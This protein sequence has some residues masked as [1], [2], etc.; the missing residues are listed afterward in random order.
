MLLRILI[1]IIIFLAVSICAVAQKTT[2]YL[3]PVNEY[4]QAMELYEH[5]KYGAAQKQFRKAIRK[6]SDKNSET[7]IN[8]EYYA[9]LC[10]AELFHKDAEFLFRQFIQAHPES[11]K[12]RLAHFQLGRYNFRKKSWERTVEWLAK[13]DIYDLS[14]EELPEYYFKLGYSYFMID[15][16]ES[17]SKA[18]FEIKDVDTKYTAPANYYY[19]HIAYFKGNYET[20]LGGFKRL[21]NHEKFK[22]VIPYYITQIYYKQEKYDDVISYAPP[23]LDS[24]STRRAPEI[25]RL[26]G[27]SYYRTNR[28]KESV[29]YLEKYKQGVGAGALKK[30]DWYQLAYAYFKSENYDKAIELFKPLANANDSIAQI[31]LYHLGEAYMKK[32][33]KTNALNVFKAASQLE[34]DKE[35]QENALFSYAKLAYETSFDPHFKAVE[36]FWEYYDKFPDSEKRDEVLAYLVNLYLTTKNYKAAMISLEAIKQPSEQL[37]GVHQFVAYNLGV[38]YFINGFYKPGIANFQKVQKYPIDKNLNAMSYYWMGEANYRIKNYDAAIANYKEFIF[39]PRAILQKEFNN[40]NYNIGYSYFKKKDYP[41]AIEWFR[42]FVA[43]KEEADLAKI[44]DSYLRIADGYYIGQQYA[45]AVEYYEKAISMKKADTDYAMFQKAVALGILKKNDEKMAILST[46]LAEFKESKY[47]VDATYQLAK[48]YMTRNENDKALV[49]FNS[50]VTNYPNSSYVK[51]SMLN[52]AQIYYNNNELDKS[53]EVFKNFVSNYP[54]FDDSQAALEQVRNIYTKLNKVDEYEAY[55][56]GLGFVDITQASLDSATY[57]AA[58]NLYT[59]NDCEKAVPG[60]AKYIEKFSD[61]IFSLPASFYKAE[62]NY[63][64]KNFEEAL[65]GYT[66]VI[67]KPISKFTETALLKASRINFQNKNYEEALNNYIMLERMA[68]YKNNILEARI[69]QMRCFYYLRNYDSAT[70]YANKVLLSDKVEDKVIAEAHFIG[71]KSAMELGNFETA[72]MELDTCSKL[73]ENELGAEAKYTK[74]YI[75]F[76]RQ[77]YK[78]SEK[79]IF[80]LVNRIPSYDYW[81]ARALL[82]LADIYVANYDGFQAK[83]TLQSII[84][85]YEGEEILAIARQKLETIIKAEKALKEKEELKPLEKIE[86]EFEKKDETETPDVDILDDGKEDSDL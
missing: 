57:E 61:G 68:E 58:Y 15:S 59:D 82:L 67:G 49:Y 60:F 3:H 48:S 23:L 12:V 40:T 13:V 18:F 42:K 47:A 77:A 74:A 25:A 6:I 38:D 65:A 31:C 37:K 73:T 69:G 22:D 43:D 16:L 46:L 63:N 34:F 32:N 45:D 5:Q 35:I 10:A 71:G 56:K 54:N 52:I 51:K 27:E 4:Q 28:Y 44:N 83:Q 64:R 21:E 29:P 1:A 81:I 30:E 8:A 17:A 75:L 41:S 11:P 7:S 86:I 9:A 24:A 66:Y 20:A 70:D 80:E 2:L 26:L 53:L 78:E 14:N 76:I 85:N 72:L 19:S 62:C 84:D 55:V 36:A 79:E 50:I 39:Q 33:E